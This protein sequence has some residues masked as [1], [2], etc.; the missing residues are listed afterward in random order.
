MREPVTTI[1]PCAA[2]GEACWVSPE[3]W[4]LTLGVESASWAKAGAAPTSMAMPS[5]VNA[6]LLARFR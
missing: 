5:A 6:T 1:S 3:G 4:L 2:G